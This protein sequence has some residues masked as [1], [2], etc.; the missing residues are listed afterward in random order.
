MNTSPLHRLS[1]PRALQA[2]RNHVEQAD[3]DTAP[4]QVPESKDRISLGKIA[5]GLG[6]AAVALTGCTNPTPPAA[7]P[8]AYEL[9][10]PEVVVMSDSVQRIDISRETREDCTGFGEERSCHTEN[11]SYH[12]IG[13]HVGEGVVQD[14]NGNL[15][16]APQ[17]VAPGTPGIAVANPERVEVDGPLGH[18]GRYQREDENTFHTEDSV[19]GKKAIDFNDNEIVVTNRGLFG[20]ESM[21]VTLDG[22]V[23][24][25]KEGRSVVSLIQSQGDHLLVQSRYGNEQAQ[26]RHQD[27]SYE[28]KEPGLFGGGTTTMNYNDQEITRKNGR[29][30]GDAVVR[31]RLN[32]F[33]VKSGRHT[34]TTTTVN[35]DGWVDQ[36]EGLFGS[37][38]TYQ[39][40]GGSVL[41]G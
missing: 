12:P 36:Y 34:E 23:A 28:V 38:M 10:S 30:N 15:F 17:L 31:S 35:E 14:L 16:A 41:P 37:K 24:T 4:A 18:D 21:R 32:E 9:E 5:V 25:V 33:K 29:W 39:F 2:P 26:I 13:I 1:P 19:F 22:G 27:G 7:D 20:G 40:S 11:V 8:G 3:A 6:F